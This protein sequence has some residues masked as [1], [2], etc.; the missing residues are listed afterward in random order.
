MTI[1]VLEALAFGLGR[2]VA[3][4]EAGGRRPGGGGTAVPCSTAT[5][6]DTRGTF[7]SHQSSLGADIVEPWRPVIAVS[8]R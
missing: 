3:A 2:M 1:A 5:G 7:G 8:S 6:L 4:I